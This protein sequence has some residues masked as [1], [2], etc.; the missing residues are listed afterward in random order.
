[1]NPRF[2]SGRIIKMSKSK[3]TMTF[4]EEEKKCGVLVKEFDYC[5]CGRDMK[6]G[7]VIYDFESLASDIGECNSKVIE[8]FNFQCPDDVVQPILSDSEFVLPELE[9]ER[10][11]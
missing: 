1:M 3:K 7:A 2:A 9:D 4:Q 5:I 10:F 6:T 11:F 8:W